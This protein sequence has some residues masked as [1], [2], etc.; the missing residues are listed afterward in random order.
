M[1]LIESNGI[2]LF[3]FVRHNYIQNFAVVPTYILKMIWFIFSRIPRSVGVN[4]IMKLLTWL[5]VTFGLIALVVAPI[6]R[7]HEVSQ[8]Q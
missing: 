2:Q 5:V 3:I 6:R 4:V 8:R 1:E 7:D